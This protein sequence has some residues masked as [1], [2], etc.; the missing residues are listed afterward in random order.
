MAVITLLEVAILQQFAG[1]ASLVD[2]I[3]GIFKVAGER[4]GLLSKYTTSNWV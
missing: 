4:S 3:C 2:T 1:S